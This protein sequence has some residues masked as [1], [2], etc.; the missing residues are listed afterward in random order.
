MLLSENCS[1]SQK[2]AKL[3]SEAL[4]LFTLLIAHL[5]KHGKLNGDPYFIKGLVVP[6]PFW[7]RF[8]VSNIAVYLTEISTYTNVKWFRA[9]DGLLYIHSLN[10]SEHNKNLI[11]N[12][13]KDKFPSYTNEPIPTI[14]DFAVEFPSTVALATAEDGT[15]AGGTPLAP[16]DVPVM[17]VGVP[18][19][20]PLI[21]FDGEWQDM[22]ATDIAD[23]QAKNPLVDVRHQLEELA[24]WLEKN[25]T[26]DAPKDKRRS[27]QQYKKNARR[28]ISNCL[29]RQ[30]KEL[31][32]Q[33]GNVS[34]ADLETK[35]EHEKSIY[36]DAVRKIK[37]QA[38]QRGLK[39]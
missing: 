33:A 35:A 19:K 21:T 10:Y 39:I 24:G 30:Q 23:W 17:P 6:D 14:T 29:T 31:K 15:P 38:V 20:K 32:K 18:D 2:L 12:I 25:D 4:N 34:A 22:T 7:S 8:N 13:G 11:R 5:S 36:A 27:A 28:W 1:R 26:P 37:T 16:K 3:S 9:A